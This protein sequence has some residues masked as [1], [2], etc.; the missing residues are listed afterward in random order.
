MLFNVI[1]PFFLK[2][3]STDLITA[4]KTFAKNYHYLK[5]NEIIIKDQMKYYNAKLKLFKKGKL[6]INL[7]PYFG[8]TTISKIP[9]EDAIKNF[10][11]HRNIGYYTPPMSITSETKEEGKDGDDGGDDKEEIMIVSPIPPILPIPHISPLHTLYP[12]A[13]FFPFIFNRILG[14]KGPELFP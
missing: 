11:I 9:I 10:F 3:K 14:F 2:I 12:H 5:I 13:S 7:S 4:V 8:P 6:G 1:Q